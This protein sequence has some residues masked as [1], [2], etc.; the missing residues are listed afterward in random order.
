VTDR[1]LAVLGR[2]LVDPAVPIARSDDP[3]LSRGDGCFEGCRVLTAPDG[4]SVIDKLDAHLARLASSAA[5]L[6]IG[7]DAAPWR[8]LIEE[9]LSAWTT[10]GEAAMKLVLTRGAL[11]FA[12]INPIPADYPRLRR[13]GLSVITLSRGTPH[14]AFADAPWLLGGVKTLSYVV[15]MAAQREAVRRGADDVIFVSTDGYVLDATTSSVVWTDGPTLCTTPTGPS[16]ILAST[17]VQR[18]F[19]RADEDGWPIAVRPASV[20]ELHTADV[21]WLVGTVRGPIDVVTLDGVARSRNP[22]VDARVRRLAG[23]GDG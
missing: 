2:G 17:T 8:A 18:L 3:G 5:A 22:V 12:T 4:T 13:D 15:N 7:F 9:A 21:L 11:G 20:A 1:V 16:G 6:E 23:F 19:E 10:P 14:D